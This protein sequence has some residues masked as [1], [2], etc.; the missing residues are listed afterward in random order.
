MN[1]YTVNGDFI[2]DCEISHG[3]QTWFSYQ[4]DKGF[5]FVVLVDE[6]GSFYHFEVFYLDLSRE[7]HLIHENFSSLSY[8]IEDGIIVGITKNGKCVFIPSI[9]T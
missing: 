3:V 2:K 5:D 6:N 7:I 1:L 9:L 4:D 8:I